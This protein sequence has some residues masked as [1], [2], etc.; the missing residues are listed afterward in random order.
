MKQLLRLPGVRLRLACHLKFTCA[1][2]TYKNS[3]RTCWGS[4]LKMRRFDGM[5]CCM[6]L[7]TPAVGE[8]QYHIADTVSNSKSVPHP[9][10]ITLRRYQWQNCGDVTHSY[11]CFLE[12]QA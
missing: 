3:P 8:I 6:I 10:P 4:V 1:V 9:R 5:T 2:I 7:Y 12:E 11:N